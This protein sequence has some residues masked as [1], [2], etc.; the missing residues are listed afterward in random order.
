MES[1]WALV[2]FELEAKDELLPRL[3]GAFKEAYDLRAEVI[4]QMGSG[5]LDREV[6][7]EDMTAIQDDLAA[8]LEEILGE[9]QMAR[10]QELRAQR[11]QAWQRPRGRGSR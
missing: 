11:R 1:D 4:E 9:D 3:R 5:E 10:L 7:R 2:C 8:S 6:M